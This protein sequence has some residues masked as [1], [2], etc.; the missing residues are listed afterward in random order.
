MKRFPA[1]LVC[2]LFLMVLAACGLGTHAQV[3]EIVF[4]NTRG[5]TTNYYLIGS[6]HGDDINLAG[7]S[8]VVTHFTFMYFGN[9]LTPS[10]GWRIR[11]YRNDGEREYPTVANTQKPKTLIWESALYPVLP[12]LQPTTLDVP[13]VTVPDR[14]TWT[15]EFQDLAQDADN[16][17]GLIIA[18]P[19]TVGALL[20]GKNRNV[21]GSYTDFWKLEEADVPDSWALNM[22]STNPDSGP[23]G[24][25][26]ARVVTESVTNRAPVWASAVNRRVSEGSVLSFQLR[27][28]DADLPAQPLAYRLAS[29]PTG[30]T[31][32]TNGLLSWQ[33]TEA[34]G[35]STNRVRVEVSDGVAAVAQEFEIVV[36]ERNTPP[37]LAPVGTRRVSEGQRLSFQIRA[38]DADLPAQAL[39]Y[40]LV[41]GPVGLSVTTNGVLSWLPTFEQG[42]STNRVR[43]SASDPF[44]AVTQDFDIIVRDATPTAPEASL[45]LVPGSGRAW[46]LHLRATAGVAFQVEQTT[47]L[48]GEGW[49]AVPG[50]GPVA[51]RG[52]AEPVV[53]PLAEDASATRFYRVRRP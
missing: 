16:G 51:G 29:G 6:Q 42:P 28:T 47:R 48:T 10:G 39:T 27:A 45:A 44:G 38:T 3:P 7:T 12:G 49:T 32:S 43:V 33:P 53:L 4:D 20:P 23:Q 18:H 9:V 25:F 40:R 5:I 2:S 52:P 11:F 21:I 26:Y 36:Q 35:P 15:V 13:R 17:A 37:T 24:N 1:G 19:P 22:F 31:V 14:F 46:N 34:Q 41:S 50:L 8:R 30:L